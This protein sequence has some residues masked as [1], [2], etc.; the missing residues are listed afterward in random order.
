MEKWEGPWILSCHG[1]DGA[2]PPVDGA[3][4]AVYH[5]SLT[6]GGLFVIFVGFFSSFPS[7]ILSILLKWRL[8]SSFLPSTI[9]L[10]EANYG[11]FV[12]FCPCFMDVV[13]F[14][15]NDRQKILTISFCMQFVVPILVCAISLF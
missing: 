10:N 6:G 15:K 11:Q 2:A 3:S 13:Y 4:A 5:S 14:S 9:Y 7:S 12:A 8:L 1:G